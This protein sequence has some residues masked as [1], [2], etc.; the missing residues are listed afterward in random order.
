M[1]RRDD[2]YGYDRYKLESDAEG[3]DFDGR[4]SFAPPPPRCADCRNTGMRDD[5]TYCAC[6]IGT[7]RFQHLADSI[8]CAKCHSTG[9]LNAFAFCSCDIGLARMRKECVN[10]EDGE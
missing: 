3:R 6:D 10:Q 2:F 5:L 7:A 1:A 4:T 9:R 8:P